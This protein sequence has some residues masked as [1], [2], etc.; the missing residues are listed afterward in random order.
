MA[1]SI[2]PAPNGSAVQAAISVAMAQVGDR[3]QFAGSGP[4]AW[5]CSGLTKAAYAAAGIFI[6]THSA[7]NQFNTM[8]AQRRL[9]PLNQLQPG[10]LMWYTQSSS[11]NGDKYHVVI[12]VGGGLMLEAPNPSAV[13]RIVPIRWGELA[14]YAGRPSA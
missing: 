3:Y 14:P 13:V 7:T 6:G 11:F 8:A 4:D 5:D 10:D 9:V 12:F 1:G 2:R